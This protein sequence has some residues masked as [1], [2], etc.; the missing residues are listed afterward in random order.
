MTGGEGLQAACPRSVEEMWGGKE[1]GRRMKDAG[2]GVDRD[3]DFGAV[4]GV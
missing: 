4:M 3:R 1:R 2:L